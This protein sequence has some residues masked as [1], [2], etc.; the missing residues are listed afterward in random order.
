MGADDP[1]IAGVVAVVRL[2]LWYHALPAPVSHQASYSDTPVCN[3]TKSSNEKVNSPTAT[4]SLV[5][6]GCFKTG[7]KCSCSKGI[8]T[9]DGLG[10]KHGCCGTI[11]NLHVLGEWVKCSLAVGDEV[12]PTWEQAIHAGTIAG[13]AGSSADVGVGQVAPGR[14]SFGLSVQLPGD[15]KH[16]WMASGQR[17]HSQPR[18]RCPEIVRVERICGRLAVTATPAI[19]KV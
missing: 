6:G 5:P 18:L 4:T 16:G 3:D 2:T 10:K 7:A 12:V 8:W 11:G 1:V 17:V 9:P 15:C 14:V 19:G 13:P